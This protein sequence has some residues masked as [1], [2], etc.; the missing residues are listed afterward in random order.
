LRVIGF[1]PVICNFL[2]LTARII[3]VAAVGDKRGAAA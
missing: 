3:A 2:Y 1:A